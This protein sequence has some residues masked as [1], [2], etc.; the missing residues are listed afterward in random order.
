MRTIALYSAASILLLVMLAEPVRG[1]VRVQ[2]YGQSA[3]VIHGGSAQYMWYPP[4]HSRGPAPYVW[5]PGFQRREAPPLS[6]LPAPAPPYGSTFYVPGHGYREFS[7]DYYWDLRGLHGQVPPPVVYPS[8]G[9]Y[10]SRQQPR[11]ITRRSEQSPRGQSP[12]GGSGSGGVMRPRDR[13]Q[14]GR[15]R[16]GWNN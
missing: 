13:N 12:R 1:E 5:Y 6:D 14:Q 10:R 4:S 9:D 15:S 2:S 7:G 8:R 16:Y 11:G 3:T